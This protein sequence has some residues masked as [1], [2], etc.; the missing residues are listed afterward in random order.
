MSVDGTAGADTTGAGTPRAPPRI[1]QSSMAVPGKT[2]DYTDGRAPYDLKCQFPPNAR[3]HICWEA[4]ILAVALV[5]LVC[6]TTVALVFS[7]G[8]YP[9]TFQSNGSIVT[10]TSIYRTNGVVSRGAVNT[11]T[12]TKWLIHRGEER[13]LALWSVGCR[14]LSSPCLV[15]AFSVNMLIAPIA[16]RN[17]WPC[18]RNLARH[19][20]RGLYGVSN[21]V[22]FRRCEWTFDEHRQ[23]RVWYDPRKMSEPYFSE[24]NPPATWSESIIARDQFGPKGAGLM[25]LPRRSRPSVYSSNGEASHR[26]PRTKSFRCSIQRPTRLYGR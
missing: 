5:V 1:D 20:E 2:A 12:S 6:C 9:V 8:S 24:A 7:G 22:F 19:C 3:K 11:T 13:K 4:L 14:R 16:T 15:E 25:V 18:W 21:W 26:F 17:F 10:L 23:C